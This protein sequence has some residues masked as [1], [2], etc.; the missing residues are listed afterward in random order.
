MSHPSTTGESATATAAATVKDPVCGMTVTPGQARGGSATHDGNDYWFCNP[1]CRDKFL[2][3]PDR[4]LAAGSAARSSPTSSAASA[5]PQVLP[6]GQVSPALPAVA[7][8]PDSPV[9]PAAPASSVPHTTAAPHPPAA[10]PARH[11]H[12]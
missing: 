2:A 10:A 12:S 9:P 11:E 5:A 8:S 1:R 3:E 7:R 4:Y 6:A